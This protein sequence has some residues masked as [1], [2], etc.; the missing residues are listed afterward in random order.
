MTSV[1]FQ[2]FWRLW[3]RAARSPMFLIQFCIAALG[4]TVAQVIVTSSKGPFWIVTSLLVLISLN[5]S[6]G[7]LVQLG[8]R[9]DLVDKYVTSSIFLIEGNKGIVY[10]LIGVLCSQLFGIMASPVYLIVIGVVLFEIHFD[11]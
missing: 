8:R 4:V 7:L 9:L 2:Q 5:V 1:K 11:E 10:A 3:L 6:V